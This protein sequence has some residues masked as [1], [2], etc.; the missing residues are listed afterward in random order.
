MA[1]RPFSKWP[2]GHSAKKKKQK[3]EVWGAHAPHLIK[4]RKEAVIGPW[5]KRKKKWKG[6]F[7]FKV[8]RTRTL[9]YED[10]TVQSSIRFRKHDSCTRIYVFTDRCK[11]M[12][13]LEL[14]WGYPNH[15][16]W[17]SE[18]L[19]YIVRWCLRDLVLKSAQPKCLY[20]GCRFCK[21]RYWLVH[22]MYGMLWLAHVATIISHGFMGSPH[23]G[24]LF[25]AR[26][27]RGVCI[28]WAY[29][30]VWS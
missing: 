18:I 2:C 17:F 23:L 27:L 25:M 15:V 8:F 22:L 28:C 9:I 20:F 12:G 7:S 29:I 24:I 1:I 11:V 3:C 10:L 6:E 5:E 19:W 16:F 30:L 4:Q 13:Y 14:A 21:N 26:V